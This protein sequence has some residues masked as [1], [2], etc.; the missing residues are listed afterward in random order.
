MTVLDPIEFETTESG[1]AV[2]LLVFSMREQRL[3]Y[4]YRYTRW[5]EPLIPGEDPEMINEFHVSA[6]YRTGVLGDVIEMTMHVIIP[7]RLGQV[8]FLG[9][10][11]SP[12]AKT[13][14]EFRYTRL[15]KAFLLSELRHGRH[16]LDFDQ[17]RPSLMAPIQSPFPI[18][19]S[20]ELDN[21]RYV[22]PFLG[23]DDQVHQVRV[24]LRLIKTSQRLC[25]ACMDGK[26]Q[27]GAGWVCSRCQI[28][29]CVHMGRG[30]AGGGPT[31]TPL[32]VRCVHEVRS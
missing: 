18:A 8:K 5:P 27:P 11:I 28:W 15:G 16:V 21:G 20:L 13:F 26:R 1:A 9:V 14:L 10:D 7:Q 24:P 29:H 6:D 19:C 22:I 32:C 4:D 2:Q 23:N 25:S 17:L 31:A 30:R 3:I 12:G